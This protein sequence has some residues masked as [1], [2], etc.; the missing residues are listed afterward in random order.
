[1][2][3]IKF[4]SFLFPKTTLN[5]LKAFRFILQYIA[6]APFKLKYIKMDLFIVLKK[7]ATIIYFI[8]SYFNNNKSYTYVPLILSWSW[9]LKNNTY[10]TNNDHYKFQQQN[11][12]KND[13]LTTVIKLVC[14]NYFSF[15]LLYLKIYLHLKSSFDPFISLSANQTGQSSMHKTN[16][17]TLNFDHLWKIITRPCAVDPCLYIICRLD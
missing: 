14:N 2:W 16:L 6:I 11:T 3:K 8:S 13:H 10:S 9:K 4:C 1:M 7:F 5:S 12:L 17:I 15:Y